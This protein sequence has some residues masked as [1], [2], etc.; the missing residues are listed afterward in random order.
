MQLAMLSNFIQMRTYLIKLCNFLLTVLHYFESNKEIEN[1]TVRQ[2]SVRRLQRNTGWWKLVWKTY[3][4]DRFKK[5]FRL[6]K[7]TFQF[8]LDRIYHLLKKQSITEDAISP[9]SRLG[10][11]LYRLGRG[12]YYYTFLS[13]AHMASVPYSC[14]RSCR[15]AASFGYKV[16]PL[17]GS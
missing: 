4:E 13:M 14:N 16:I 15:Y 17:S 6:T 3:S 2:R 5:T 7:E 8:I 12:D 9:E 11:C 10:V 1:I